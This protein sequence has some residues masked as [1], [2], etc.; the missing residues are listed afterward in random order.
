MQLFEFG[1]FISL[2]Y[3]VLFLPNKKNIHPVIKFSI[4]PLLYKGMIIIPYNKERAI[5]LHHW[6]IYLFICFISF[7]VSIPRILCG[8]SFGLFLQGII[9][10]DRFKFICKNPYT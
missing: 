4:P 7:I 8:L 10:K 3:A 9:Y 5:H 2:V 6:I 1:V